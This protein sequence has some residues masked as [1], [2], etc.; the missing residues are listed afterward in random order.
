[1]TVTG[2]EGAA[3]SLPAPGGAKELLGDLGM[4]VRQT[5]YEQLAFWLNRIGAVFTIGFSVV[6]LELVGSNHGTTHSV[7]H[8]AHYVQYYVPGFAAYGVMAACFNNL[9]IGIVIRR[10]TG[11]LKRLRLSPIPTW[12]LLGA[13]FASAAVIAAVQV[14]LLLVIGRVQLSV[15]FP[16]DPAA[17]VVAL[18][19]G[20]VSFT[21]LGVAMST[22][23]PNQD[24]AGPITS[25]VFFVFLF[26]SGLWFPLATGST[27]AK[28][29]GWFPVR[30]FILACV[31]PFDVTPGVSAW[32]WHDLAWVAGWGVLGTVV[33]VRRFRWSPRR[34]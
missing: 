28:I 9:S 16:Q 8:G 12:A 31:R 17:F 26:L 13:I 33:A 34:S 20:I 27:L 14:V 30:H 5:K 24:T 2:G 19:V 32:A 6:F 7:L 1:M 11:L 22:V 18:V 29:S 15:H 23:I 21:A 25:V 10:E 3:L 4:V